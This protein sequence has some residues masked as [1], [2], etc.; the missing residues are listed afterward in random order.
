MSNE[1]KQREW[2]KI[3]EYK[4]LQAH[5]K[6]MRGLRVKTIIKYSLLGIVLIPLALLSLLTGTA[7]DGAVKGFDQ[8]GNDHERIRRN[9]NR[10]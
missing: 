10:F 3:C 5:K 8:L 4:A 2:K 1:E 9:K 6:Q 7:I